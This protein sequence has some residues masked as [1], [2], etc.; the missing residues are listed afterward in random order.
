MDKRLPEDKGSKPTSIF[1]GDLVQAISETELPV[2]EDDA[3]VKIKR[4]TSE[5]LLELNQNA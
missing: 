1:L 2:K 3:L 5:T 4:R